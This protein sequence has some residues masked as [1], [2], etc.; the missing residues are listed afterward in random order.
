MSDNATGCIKAVTAI[1]AIVILESVAMLT[2]HN[3]TVLRLSI[4]AVAGLGGFVIG[5]LFQRRK[6]KRSNVEGDTR[7]AAVDR[8]S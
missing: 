1:A 8:D 5:R 6:E 4:G 2:G 7:V 3:G